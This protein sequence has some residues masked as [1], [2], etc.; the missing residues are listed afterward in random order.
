MVRW[1]ALTGVVQQIEFSQSG[2]EV[3]HVIARDLLRN[4][5]FL[6]DGIG[7]VRRVVFVLQKFDD[8]NANRVEAEDK[9]TVHIEQ[10]A[11]VG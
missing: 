1:T 10:D 9:P 5:E 7:K 8:A 6:T 11:A 4:P 3:G 2:Q